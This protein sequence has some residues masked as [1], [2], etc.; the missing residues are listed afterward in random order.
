MLENASNPLFEMYTIRTIRKATPAEATCMKK[1]RSAFQQIKVYR[2]NMKI[3][4][5]KIE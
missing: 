2:A 3:A 4:T 1:P 5:C